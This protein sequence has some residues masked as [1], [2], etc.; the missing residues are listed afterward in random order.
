[1]SRK[2]S[3]DGGERRKKTKFA[4]IKG[5]MS[6]QVCRCGGGGGAAAAAAAAAAGAAATVAAVRVSVSEGEV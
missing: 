5:W 2:A 4:T 6:K 3:V 1:M